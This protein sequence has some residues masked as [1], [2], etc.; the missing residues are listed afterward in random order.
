MKYPYVGKYKS[1]KYMGFYILFVS[2]KKGC[3]VFDLDDDYKVGHFCD[4][5]EENHFTPVEAT[6]EFGV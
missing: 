4:C 3:V 6:I 1:N 5:W 2:N